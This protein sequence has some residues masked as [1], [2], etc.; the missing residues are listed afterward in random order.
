MELLYGKIRSIVSSKNKSST[1][2][3]IKKG[4]CS[5]SEHLMVALKLQTQLMDC[6]RKI[7]IIFK[8]C[9]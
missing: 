5:Y 3:S 8:L 2:K 1:F 7:K 6:P 9:I 4:S